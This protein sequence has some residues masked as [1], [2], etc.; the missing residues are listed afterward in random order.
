MEI[1]AAVLSGLLA[2]AGAPG[3][4]IDRLITEALRGQLV[5]ADRLE[6]RL[7]NTPNYQLL[8]GKIDRVRLAG[9]GI[10]LSS[11]LRIDTIDLESDPISI[12]PN[13]LQSGQLVLLEPAQAAARVILKAEDINRALRSPTITSS[14]RGIKLSLSPNDTT[15]AKA[16]EF[17]LINPQVTFLGDNRLRLNATLQPLSKPQ[18]GLQIAIESS[19]VVVDST[20]LELTASTI[21]LQGI[22]VPEQITSTLA[23][24][25]NRLLDFRQLEASGIFARI[26]KL[27][28]TESQMQLIGFARMEPPKIN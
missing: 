18:S 27:E 3:V 8:Q 6:V 25:I 23:R 20:R 13:F 22:T 24:G 26:L 12:N 21:N 15:N 28:V 19:I 11:F 2:G 4:V 5:R 17:D 16:E 9:R 14:F 1:F 7:D 10:Y